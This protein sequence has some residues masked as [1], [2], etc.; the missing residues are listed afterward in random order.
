MAAAARCCR[1]L[2]AIVVFG[3]SVR[4]LS[5]GMR[6]QGF[7]ENQAAS[8]SQRYQT[9]EAA[10]E[11]LLRDEASGGSGA[12]GAQPP[13]SQAQQAQPPPSVSFTP[14]EDLE[15]R[16]ENPAD[17]TSAV[18][19]SWQPLRLASLSSDL[20][21]E[22]DCGSEPAAADTAATAAI[23][24]LQAEQAVDD[25]EA[26]R[27]KP[28]AWLSGD[29]NSD[30]CG[31]TFEVLHAC[32]LPSTSQQQLLRDLSRT[33]L[34]AAFKRM[35]AMGSGDKERS[36]SISMHDGTSTTETADDL[37]TASPSFVSYRS[38][39]ACSSVT[40]TPTLSACLLTPG[41]PSAFSVDG[42]VDEDDEEERECVVCLDAT[43][44]TNAR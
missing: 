9:L 11:A 38:H 16:K 21:A 10:L 39:S 18:Y 43:K 32:G 7:S 34:L 20:T 15:E 41:V 8:Y 6:L 42:S 12:S 17:Y 26:I 28:I 25:C 33:A 22:S 14:L 44:V 36:A 27:E 31:D 29:G 30:D 4:C 19:V 23:E 1:A 35:A 40:S 24:P 3:W 37:S 5:F 13:P 2:T